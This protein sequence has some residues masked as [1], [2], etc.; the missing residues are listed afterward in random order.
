M[1]TLHGEIVRWRSEPKQDTGW[2]IVELQA[3]GGGVHTV[4]GC[5]LP[6]PGT[7]VELQ[8]QWESHARYGEQFHA[9]V[10]AKARPSLNADGVARWMRERCEGIGPKRA[11]ELLAAFGGNAEQLWAAAESGLGGRAEVAALV[12]LT[13]EMAAGISEALAAEGAAGQY[14]ALL[15]GWGMTQRQIRKVKQHWALDE[16]TELLRANPYLLADHIDGFGFGRADAVATKLG[17]GHN[18]DVRVR[19]ALLHFIEAAAGEG[20]VFADELVLRQIARQTRLPMERLMR[21][22]RELRDLGRLVVQ[23]GARIYLPDLCAAEGEVA[24]D[25][26][27]RFESAVVIGTVISTRG[28]GSV[29]I[30]SNV[31]QT[32]SAP[33]EPDNFRVVEARG[34]MDDPWQARAIDAICNER[35]RVVFVTGGPGTGKTTVLRRALERLRASGARVSLAAP[36]GKA[37]KRMTEATGQKAMTL[38][39]LLGYRPTRTIDCEVC[40]AAD[41]EFDFSVIQSEEPSVVIVDEASMVD[42]RL[43]QALVQSARSVRLV[44]VGDANQLPPVGPGQPFKDALEV[45]PADCV[46]RLRTVFRSKGEW[47]KL[48]APQVLAGK[49]PELEPS[50]GLRFV[51]TDMADAIVPTIA[52]L[53]QG[54]HDDRYFVAGNA[55]ALGHM[56][57]LAPQRTGSAGVSA[58]NRALHDMLN[59]GDMGDACVELED[60]NALRVGAWVMFQKN[61]TRRKICNGDTGYVV[62]IDPEKKLVGVEVEGTTEPHHV[63][64][65]FSEAREQLKLA[66]GSTV[67]KAQGSEYP[68]VVVVAHS[69]H[70]RMLTRRLLYTAI[71]RAK[72]GVVLVGDHEGIEH[73][74][75][76]AREVQR[77]TWL[78]ERITGGRV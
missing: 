74:V 6:R 28:D 76:N 71:T 59:P 42:V 52:Q 16:A 34:N 37:A 14:N 21:G 18:D 10:V 54:A 75:S 39:S 66:Y 45:A 2:H 24:A 48:A 51:R 73:A 30:E 36:T 9:R 49:V 44:F 72:E 40:K 29:V 70:K 26:C 19:A 31:G 13:P 67:H 8:G 43:W 62:S 63:S 53:I 11:Q 55:A 25:L 32:Q 15:H 38:H 20:H 4:T 5:S 3:E 23:D 57:I 78:R 60:N 22:V 50:P 61:D 1:D 77:C 56:P 12:W 7:Q 17:I 33:P 46:V 47:V 35:L 65:T 58:I 41:A 27:A 68:W 69:T 64:F